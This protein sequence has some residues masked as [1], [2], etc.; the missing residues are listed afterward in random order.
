MKI[1][2]ISD[3][4]G[5]WFIGAFEPTVLSTS[6]F[7]VG[8]KTYSK[9]EYHAPHFHKIATEINYLIS[10]KIIANKKE[11]SV[12]QIFIFEP[13]EIA[14]CEFLE[15]TQIL[16]VK[17]PSSEGDKYETINEEN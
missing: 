11:I 5:G 9:G 6:Q 16:V 10:G 2:E 17:V 13:Y 15:D 1:V 8:V 7:E 14:E 12:G 4:K 3:M